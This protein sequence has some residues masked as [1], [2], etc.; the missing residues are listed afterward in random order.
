MA[1]QYAKSTSGDGVLPVKDRAI[2][3][4][5][6]GTYKLGDVVKLSSGEVVASAAGDTVVLGVLEGTNFE[7]LENARKVA[8]VRESQEAIY[9]APYGTIAAGV[10]TKVTPAASIIGLSKAV[11][12]ATVEGY[13]VN[14]DTAATG[15]TLKI[16]DIDV[17][18][19]EVYVKFIAT[20]LATE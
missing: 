7:G 2:N 9:K 8:K 1:F 10:L 13:V 16:V 12:Y 14:S 17:A 18:N 4:T 15:K 3:A 5:Y 11:G 6:A 20:A 19:K